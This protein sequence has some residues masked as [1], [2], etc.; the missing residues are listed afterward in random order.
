MY[1]SRHIFKVI[2]SLP[3]V[4]L[5]NMLLIVCL[6]GLVDEGLHIECVTQIKQLRLETLSSLLVVWGVILESRTILLDSSSDLKANSLSS[7]THHDIELYGISLITLGLIIEISDYVN[8]QFQLD[9]MNL[10]ALEATAMI[11]WIVLVIILFD[12]SW[13]T[14]RILLGL[15]NH[16]FRSL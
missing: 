14:W 11:Q 1:L 7:E 9:Q 16:R 15:W 6:I 13:L 10:I 2:I 8:S 4:L 3:F 5:S 12:T